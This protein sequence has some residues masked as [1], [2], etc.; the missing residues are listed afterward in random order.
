MCTSSEDNSTPLEDSPNDCPND[1]AIY[2]HF[3]RRCRRVSFG[4]DFDGRPLFTSCR[5]VPEGWEPIVAELLETFG[6]ERLVTSGIAQRQEDGHW[7]L[8]PAL[9]P[10]AYIV[11]LR[12]MKDGPIFEILT[13][14]GGLIGEEIPIVSALK[15]YQYAE[16]VQKMGNRLLACASMNQVP[17]LTALSLPATILHGL[18]NPRQLREL[19][20][21]LGWRKPE[22][23]HGNTRLSNP[24]RLVFVGLD[25]GRNRIKQYPEIREAAQFLANVE[26]CLRLRAHA[27]IWLPSQEEI[28]RYRFCMNVGDVNASR[29]A[30][31]ESMDVSSYCI[32]A[33]LTPNFAPRRR[34]EGY[35]ETWA[36]LEK[37]IN[38]PENRPVTAERLQKAEESFAHCVDEELT[39]PQRQESLENSDPLQRNL[40]VIAAETS[41]ALHL[42][43]PYLERDITRLAEGELSLEDQQRV[44][45]QLSHHERAFA[46]LIRF[47]KMQDK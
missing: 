33:F 35:M 13:S 23:S 43:S 12:E 29:E 11:A 45:K 24:V 1:S 27:A 21:I 36:E 19:L 46:N 25:L 30:L 3:W 37:C 38:T 14:R 39:Q 5:T 31:V 44:F 34:P 9:A 22:P 42:Q 28:K 26:K 41:R 18:T 2:D 4:N 32:S 20:P 8:N 10:R 6:P 47:A 40:G 15:D 16:Q 17:P 7:T